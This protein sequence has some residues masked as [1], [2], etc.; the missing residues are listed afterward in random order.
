[1][2]RVE[3]PVLF[4]WAQFKYESL[5]WRN[6]P[7]WVRG[8]CDYVRKMRKVFDIPGFEDGERWSQ[9]KECGQALEA[10][11]GKGTFSFRPSRKECSHWQI[12][13]QVR[14][15]LDFWPSLV[16]RLWSGESKQYHIELKD[17]RRA[18]DN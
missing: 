18:P 16:E 1:M 12:F 15:M 14:L 11:K 3:Y 13:S 5:K 17:L 6:I 10:G 4:M 9:A 7:G 2:R 8:K